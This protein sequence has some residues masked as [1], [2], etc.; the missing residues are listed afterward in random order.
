MIKRFGVSIPEDLLIKLDRLI[1]RKG[2]SN[3]S[4]AIRDLIR[5]R[6]VSEE[7][8]ANVSDVIGTITLVYNHH[9]KDL[10]DK[11]TDL[12][13]SHFQNIV[14]TMHVHLDPHNCMEVLVVKG[15]SDK[16]R[17]ISDKLIATKGVQHGKLVMSAIGF[18]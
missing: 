1:N 5:D 4:E 2:Y 15:K 3:R 7:W 14:S 18:N 9:V 17:E 6:F 13:H 11:L 10:S 8:N 16:V 12:Q